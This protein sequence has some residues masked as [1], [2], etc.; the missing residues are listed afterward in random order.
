MTSILVNTTDFYKFAEELAEDFN[1]NCAES[2]AD[3]LT[4]EDFYD[5][6]QKRAYYNHF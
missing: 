2:E 6:R 4:A 1:L 5:Q 3:E